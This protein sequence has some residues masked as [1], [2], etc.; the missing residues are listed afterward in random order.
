MALKGGVLLLGLKGAGSV[1]FGSKSILTLGRVDLRKRD[2]K[3]QEGK[4]QQTGKPRGKLV[5]RERRSKAQSSLS[6]APPRKPKLTPE[7]TFFF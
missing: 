7:L 2:K 3:R 5:T 1:A 4:M 6:S